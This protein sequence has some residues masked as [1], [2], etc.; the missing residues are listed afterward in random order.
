MVATTPQPEAIHDRS[1]LPTLTS[2][3]PS[4]WDQA[5]YAFLVEKGNRSGSKRTVESYRRIRCESRPDAQRGPRGHI[6]T[7]QC[8]NLCSNLADPATH[9]LSYGRASPDRLRATSRESLFR[10]SS[11]VLLC[12]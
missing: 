11:K 5:L 3:S 9:R 4:A 2:G 10:T 6:D 12:L 8:S 7:R 1:A